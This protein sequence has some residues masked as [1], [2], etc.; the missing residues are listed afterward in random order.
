MF[1][2]FADLFDAIANRNF[3]AHEAYPN[4]RYECRYSY[5]FPTG[6][7]TFALA[8]NKISAPAW[9]FT[10]SDIADDLWAIFKA[11]EHFPRGIPQMRIDVFRFRDGV[12]GRSFLASEGGMM[13][14]I[15]VTANASVA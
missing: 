10:F 14:G 13:F 8:L 7:I 9:E 6:P 11:V 15:P 3:W 5:S 12:G 2:C 1:D 4:G